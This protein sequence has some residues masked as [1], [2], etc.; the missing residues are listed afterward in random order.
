MLGIRKPSHSSSVV[1]LLP[2]SCIGNQQN[3]ELYPKC[4]HDE[5]T[6]GVGFASKC[7][8]GSLCTGEELTSTGKQ[9]QDLQL[10]SHIERQEFEEQVSQLNQT[11]EETKEQMNDEI[12]SLSNYRD[13][14]DFLLYRDLCPF[15]PQISVTRKF[16]SF[17]ILIT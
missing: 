9:L 5:F 7:V 12:D 16:I 11:L 15:I 6:D 14:D 13:I 3:F 8:V 2:A 17:Y 10:T 1:R 4:A